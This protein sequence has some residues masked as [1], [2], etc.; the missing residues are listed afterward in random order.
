[1]LYL[2][3]N[4]YI[5]VK[6]NTFMPKSPRRPIGFMRPPLTSKSVSANYVSKTLVLSSSSDEEMYDGL[7]GR[8]KPD[9]YPVRQKPATKKRKLVS[10][11]KKKSPASTGNTTLD[12][13]LSAE[14]L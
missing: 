6:V 14:I 5:H 11:L 2:I 10:N 7:G 9:V 1:M 8:S 4:Y 13:F 3:I 12:N